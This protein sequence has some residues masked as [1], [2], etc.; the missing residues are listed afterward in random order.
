MV[1]VGGELGQRRL[2]VELLSELTARA[3]KLADILGD[4]EGQP[5]RPSLVDERARDR[6]ANPPRRVGRKLEAE[7]VVELLDGAHEAEVPL[8]D[9]VEKR[10]VGARVIASD[11]HDEPE[12]RLDQAPP[13]R[14]VAGVLA[15]RELSLLF[16]RQQRP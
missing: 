1:R 15:A 8:L 4:M 6:L 11:G 14:V 2:A 5:D 7:L 9:E 16:A 12:V 13:R 10:H 3:E